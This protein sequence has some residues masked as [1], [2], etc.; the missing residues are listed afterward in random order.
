MPPPTSASAS[1]NTSRRYYRLRKC[2]SF[3]IGLSHTI[4]ND[5]VL[6]DRLRLPRRRHCREY[7]SLSTSNSNNRRRNGTSHLRRSSKGKGRSVGGNCSQDRGDRWIRDGNGRRDVR[8]A[9]LEVLASFGDEFGFVVR[10]AAAAFEGEVG[11][12]WCDWRGHPPSKRCRQG[13]FVWPLDS[14]AGDCGFDGGCLVVVRRWWSCASCCYHL[15][16]LHNH[17]CGSSFVDRV[18]FGCS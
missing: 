15:R 5:P 18:D 6:C 17:D 11:V 3:T 9:L 7:H 8:R 12:C 14:D 2:N 1:T 4:G 13:S 10:Y 16:S